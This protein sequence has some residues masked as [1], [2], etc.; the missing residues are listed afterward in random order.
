[1]ATRKRAWSDDGAGKDHGA[2]EDST[3][4][5]SYFTNVAIRMCDER[6][7]AGH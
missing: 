1:V 6:D 4:G 7:Q 5:V 3:D 2:I